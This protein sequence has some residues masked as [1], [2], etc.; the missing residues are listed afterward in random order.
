MKFKKLGWNGFL[1]E[2]P[3]EM[4]L[5]AEGGNFYSG[6]LK[7]EME[8]FLIEIKWEPYQPKK[9]KPLAEIAD[10][11]IKNVKKT[12]EK[13][14]KKKIDLKV[15]NS[16]NIFISSH[17]AYY[18]IL[19]SGTKLYEP[20][21]LWNCEESKRII[22]AHFISPLSKDQSRE[23]VEHM[24]SSLKCHE[25]KKETVPWI[26]LNLRFNIPA[27]FLLSERKMTVGRTYLIFDERSPSAFVEK[28]RSL[29]VEYFSMADIIFEGLHKNLDVWFQK[30]YWKDLKKRR[31]NITFQTSE[32]GRFRRHNA[33]Y[34]RGIKRSGLLT[35]R[36]TLCENL[37]W[38]CS[39]SNRIYSITYLS[40][41]SRP[42]FLKRRLNQEE[43]KRIMREL[44]SSFKCHF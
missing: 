40:Y 14:S 32:A 10:S 4:R 31:R 6:Y 29:I 41:I 15:E 36:T 35:R 39:N 23:I 3:E 13:R 25:K 2:I 11:F 7:L 17:N 20:V 24:I 21:Y 26:A 18:M 12:I 22:I 37:T 44:L 42:F 38:Y 19:N 30:K 27:S 43:D 5:T 9:P 1:L 8:N 16:G 28:G 33:I 34:K